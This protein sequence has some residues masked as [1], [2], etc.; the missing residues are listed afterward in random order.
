MAG[1]VS[2]AS[3]KAELNQVAERC[4]KVGGSLQAAAGC[5]KA[6]GLSPPPDPQATGAPL[7]YIKNNTTYSK[8]GPW[9]GFP[10]AASCGGVSIKF[11][12]DTVNSWQVWAEIDGV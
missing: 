7:S 1:C 6:S 8:C 5:L 9:W 11:N 2:P 4:M 12:N 3:R 10:F